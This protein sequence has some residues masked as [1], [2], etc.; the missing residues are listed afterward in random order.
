ME[1]RY[2]VRCVMPHTKPDLRID[3]DRV[4]AT[5]LSLGGHGTWAWAA[6]NAPAPAIDPDTSR[7][8]T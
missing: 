2:C 7:T 8:K 3:A 1:L 6:A 4:C 5:G